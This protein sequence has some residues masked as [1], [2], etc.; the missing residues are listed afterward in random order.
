MHGSACVI[1]D[2]YVTVH[3]VFGMPAG[4]PVRGGCGHVFCYLSV[5][6]HIFRFDIMT[7]KGD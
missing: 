7:Y 2:I 4:T 6:T 1:R 3:S 5:F